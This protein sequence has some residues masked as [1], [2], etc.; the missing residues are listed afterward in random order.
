MKVYVSA[1]Q[2]RFPKWRPNNEILRELG[3]QELGPWDTSH[4]CAYVNVLL[5]SVDA[6][7][8]DLRVNVAR[9]LSV[10]IQEIDNEFLKA[11]EGL[12]K[13][14]LDVDQQIKQIARSALHSWE[15]HPEIFWTLI[16][17][18]DGRKRLE[19]LRELGHVNVALRQ[20]KDEL[21]KAWLALSTQSGRS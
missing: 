21:G 10:A 4:G 7:D 1:I 8:R 20:P 14:A 9:A 18:K 2:Q 12:V 13:L 17:K 16:Q 6:E 15:K 19:R 11:L 5:I 3:F